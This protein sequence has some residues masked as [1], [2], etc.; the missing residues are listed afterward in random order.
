MFSRTGPAQARQP[1][2]ANRAILAIFALALA[3]A[4]LV[5]LS[6]A[7][8]EQPQA[9]ADIPSQIGG[10]KLVRTLTGEEAL[11]NLRQMH[12]LDFGLTGGYVAFYERAGTVWVGDT[13][14][15]QQAQA[16]ISRMTQRIGAGSKEFTNLQPGEVSGQKLYWVEG[17]GQR[18]VF[19]A[20]GKKT[21]WVAAARGVEEA[22]IQDAVRAIR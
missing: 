13:E 14:S 8:G 15:E 7:I 1:N 9:S 11:A 21:V 12:G 16:L 22:F 5:G 3:G 10:L 17:Q 19:Y 4:V 20:R 6:F 18:H 2:P